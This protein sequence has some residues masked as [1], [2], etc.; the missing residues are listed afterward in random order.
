[1]PI[2]EE[3]LRRALGLFAER[4]KLF[5]RLF[6]WENPNFGLDP[7]WIRC[8]PYRQKALPGGMVTVEARV[9]NHASRPKQARLEMRAP[10]GWTSPPAATAMIAPRTEGRIRFQLRA[11][12]SPERRRQ[13]LGLA[14]TVEGV[15]L[16]EFA[17]AIVD[18]LAA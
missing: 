10:A 18:F 2:S 1:V 17:E 13:V 16:G 11:P 4:E 8:Y 15:R 14:A 3:Y 12:A 6:P 9:Y 7:A 5:A